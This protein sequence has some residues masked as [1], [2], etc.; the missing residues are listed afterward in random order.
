MKSKFGFSRK[1]WLFGAVTGVAFS[2]AIALWAET[3]ATQAQTP[4]AH[5]S[6]V[7]TAGATSPNGRVDSS[8][9]EASPP[10]LLKLFSKARRVDEAADSNQISATEPV[11]LRPVAITPAGSSTPEIRQTAQIGRP[12]P[13]SEVQ[14][15][16]EELY[17]RD[18]RE[19][20]PMSFPAV[21]QSARPAPIHP[22][23]PPVMVR[24]TEQQD[25]RPSLLERLFPF[26]RKRNE[27]PPQP[28]IRPAPQYEA[29]ARVRVFPP[30]QQPI[31]PAPK[32]VPPAPQEFPQPSGSPE[33]A[34]SKSTPVEAA[35]MP[36]A[37]SEE[38]E[39]PDIL[40]FEEVPAEETAAADASAEE[41]FEDP[42]G[43]FESPFTE[44]SEA[45]ADRGANP[46][47]KLT[48]DE[49]ASAAMAPHPLETES[50]A[51]QPAVADQGPVP[52]ISPA[53]E[54]PAE[55]ESPFVRPNIPVAAQETQLPEPPAVV[56][57]SKQESVEP[58]SAAVPTEIDEKLR[59][60]AERKGL[61]GLKG[62][63][64]VALR[65]DRRLLN[66]NV[67]L[68]SV[69]NSQ[70][71]YFSSAEAKLRFDENPELYA[72]MYGGHDATLL[73]IGN[74]KVKGSLD[75][76]LWYQNR[77]YLFCSRTTLQLFVGQP[78]RFAP[79]Q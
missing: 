12:T 39:K 17:R 58:P 38:V 30:A 2:P 67:E 53:V 23:T 20:P 7:T 79:K 52:T 1:G 46:V 69:Y 42:L 72:P 54:A 27:P 55:E 31:A 21:P 74:E 49:P 9:R 63:C 75:H 3:D 43:D 16:L 18:G 47:V 40:I 65:D 29:P 14:R 6:V 36:P 56:A 35:P 11:Y 4:A 66:G 8:D 41:S 70:T 44:V 13:S 76:A 48:I 32:V 78:E 71:Y 73:A 19:M 33:L 22:V 60:I 57:H 62:Y 15:Q 25:S 37:T 77:L 68:S 28:Q 26:T 34:T 5:G 59:M 50:A 64:I 51:E 45:E 24:Q 61:T 10:R